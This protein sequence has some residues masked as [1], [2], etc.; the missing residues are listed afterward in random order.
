MDN[1][2]PE[3]D[4][5]VHNDADCK[6]RHVATK[7]CVNEASNLHQKASKSTQN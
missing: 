5:A 2:A 3:F 6:E 1:G 7:I 4:V